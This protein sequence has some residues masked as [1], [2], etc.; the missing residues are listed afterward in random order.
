MPFAANIAV[1]QGV[2]VSDIIIAVL[3]FIRFDA[4]QGTFN[5]NRAP[6]LLQESSSRNVV[7]V[8]MVV[9]EG[10]Q[11]GTRVGLPSVFLHKK[12]IIYL[13][14][15]FLHIDCVNKLPYFVWLSDW[16]KK[17]PL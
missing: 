5:R 12:K 14:L 15:F 2:I 10:F 3:V 16:F 8:P 1:E 11:G 9:C 7:R 6:T 17:S 13:Q 4:H